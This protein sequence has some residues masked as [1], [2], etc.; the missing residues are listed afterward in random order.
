MRGFGVLGRDFED[1]G[2]DLFTYYVLSETYSY[3]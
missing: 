1:S 2:K 3:V